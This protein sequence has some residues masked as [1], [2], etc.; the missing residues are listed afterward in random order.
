V[1]DLTLDQALPV[2]Q[3]VASRKA[4]AFV[5]RCRLGVHER[6]D[7]QS[8]LVLTFIARWPKFDGKKAS[9]RTFAS[10]VMDMELTSILRYRLAERRRPQDLPSRGPVPSPASLRQFR[11]DLERAVAPLPDAV[12]ET[13]RALFCCSTGETAEAL[14]CSRQTINRR[15]RQIR[16]AF[17]AVGIGPNYFAAGGA[18]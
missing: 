1:V 8:H 17:L 2:V 14:G 11:I 7:V 12:H 16:E 13:A 18:R 15:K 10:H 3:Y 4:N 5:R 6:E 9:V